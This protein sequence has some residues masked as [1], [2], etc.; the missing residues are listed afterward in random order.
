MGYYSIGNSLYGTYIPSGLENVSTELMDSKEI[1]DVFHK[2]SYSY[3][4][5]KNHNNNPPKPLEH[6]FLNEDLLEIHENT[7]LVLNQLLAI[8]SEKLNGFDFGVFK[9]TNYLFRLIHYP[10]IFEK[11]TKLTRLGSHV[12]DDLLALVIA[13][14]TNGLKI[15][16]PVYGWLEIPN[17]NDVF[18]VLIGGCLEFLTEG[19]FTGTEH[20]VDCDNNA[21][22]SRYVFNINLGSDLDF[23]RH[24]KSGRILSISE[25]YQQR[26]SKYSLVKETT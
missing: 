16:T 18:V 13:E 11:N 23:R 6:L 8:F 15:K 3:E 9:K 17:L 14:N 20:R 25:Y 10:P 12:D 19:V 22:Q 1:F 24:S 2:E 4:Y 21:S 7:F 26:L 5:Y